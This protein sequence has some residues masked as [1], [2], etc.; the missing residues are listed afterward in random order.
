MALICLSPL[1]GECKASFPHV[2]E[3]SCKPPVP[4]P[5]LESQGRQSGW[6]FAMIPI[7]ALENLLLSLPSQKTLNPSLLQFLCSEA[8]GPIRDF[9]LSRPSE[10]FRYISSAIS[11]YSELALWR[12]TTNLVVEPFP[13]PTQI[14]EKLVSQYEGNLWK[15]NYQVIQL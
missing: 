14:F 13:I 8:C 6:S 1:S 7:L 4:Y 2:F 15:C 3:S 5:I 9:H 12:M 10:I 11:S